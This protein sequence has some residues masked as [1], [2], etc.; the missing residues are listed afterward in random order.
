M[1]GT[2]FTHAQCKEGSWKSVRV[3]FFRMQ[4]SSLLERGKTPREKHSATPQADIQIVGASRSEQGRGQGTAG[5]DQPC[6]EQ[7]R[8]QVPGSSESY[9][10][11]RNLSVL[12]IALPLH[13]CSGAGNLDSASGEQWDLLKVGNLWSALT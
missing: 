3:S 10:W 2:G 9:Y 4:N 11:R 5:V 8:G 1:A 12:P 13:L 6:S 7:P